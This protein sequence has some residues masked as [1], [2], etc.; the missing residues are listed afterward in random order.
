MTSLQQIVLLKLK[1]ACRSENGPVTEKVVELFFSQDSNRRAGHIRRVL[2]SL[3]KKGIVAQVPE[4]EALRF[5]PVESASE[6]N[7]A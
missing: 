4:G 5:L 7:R 6:E 1:H 3:V 2:D